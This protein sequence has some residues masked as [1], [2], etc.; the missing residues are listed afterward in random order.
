MLGQLEKQYIANNMGIEGG[1]EKIKIFVNNNP[2]FRPFDVWMEVYENCCVTKF[3]SFENL[4]NSVQ[5]RNKLK[6]RYLIQKLS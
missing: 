4:H 5:Y 2:Q 6:L 3:G 1:Y